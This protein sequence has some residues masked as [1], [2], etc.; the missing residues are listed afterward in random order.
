MG[1]LSPPTWGGLRCRCRWKE[2]VQGA[3]ALKQHP[4]RRGDRHLPIAGFEGDHFDRP[5][6]TAVRPAATRDSRGPATGGS[7]HGRGRV[8]AGG[9]PKGFVSDACGRWISGCAGADCLRLSCFQGSPP[10][11]PPQVQRAALGVALVVGGEHA[12]WPRRADRQL[13]GGRCSKVGRG[14]GLEYRMTAGPGSS[15]LRDARHDSIFE[16]HS[17]TDASQ[18]TTS[19]RRDGKLS[20]CWPWPCSLARSIKIGDK[21]A[22]RGGTTIADAG[23]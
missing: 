12:C 18:F 22:G 1:L 20:V 15:P 11:P 3:A 19:A 7:W 13:R 8:S 16:R 10:P 23:G 4:K 6:E 5:K 14:R 9:K 2:R 21:R 17:P